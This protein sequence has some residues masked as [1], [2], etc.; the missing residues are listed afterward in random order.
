M[1]SGYGAASAFDKWTGVDQARAFAP[2]EIDALLAA[3]VAVALAGFQLAALA[4]AFAA[5]RVLRFPGSPLLRF[6]MPSGGLAVLGLSVIVLVAFAILFGR[7]VYAFDRTAFLHD[8]G[9][10][11]G[12]LKTKWWWLILLAAG[13]GAPLAEECLFR[14]LLYGALRGTPLGAAGATVLTAVCWASLHAAYSAYGLLAIALIGVYFAYLRERTGSL[15]API[16]CHGAYNS[17]IV[18]LLIAM[19]QI[20]GAPV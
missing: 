16:V 5:D 3:R 15:L 19:P 17:L 14:G 6:R 1:V 8:I 9:Q 10:F 7:V 4:L 13:V 12:L 20:G 2:G 18:L 11:A